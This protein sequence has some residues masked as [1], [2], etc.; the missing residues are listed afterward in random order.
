MS[1]E[2]N[3]ALASRAVEEFLTPGPIDRADAFFSTDSVKHVPS[4]PGFSTG[5]VGF[6]QSFT[7]FRQAFPDLHST[8]ENTIAEGD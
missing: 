6:K 4:P 8:V 1:G 3:K 5:L 7:F 2:Q